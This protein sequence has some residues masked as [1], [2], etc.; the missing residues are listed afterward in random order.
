[1]TIV[2]EIYF[3]FAKAQVQHLLKL[4]FACFRSVFLA[5]ARSA[6]GQQEVGHEGVVPGRHEVSL[7]HLRTS[8]GVFRLVLFNREAHDELVS[9]LATGR[10]RL[11]LTRSLVYFLTP[12][13]HC[14][15]CNAFNYLCPSLML[16]VVQ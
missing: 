1:Y 14:S 13:L 3:A 2:T 6:S 10:C 9:A 5:A 15:F 7:L 4:R 8:C 16:L 11:W 12:Y